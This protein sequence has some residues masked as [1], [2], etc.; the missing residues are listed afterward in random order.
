MSGCS[1]LLCDNMIIEDDNLGIVMI[2]LFK[3]VRNMIK[4]IKKTIQ[5]LN[6]VT[7]KL[8]INLDEGVEEIKIYYD[9]V[10]LLSLKD[11]IVNVIKFCMSNYTFRSSIGLATTIF[12]HYG[13]TKSLLPDKFYFN[14]HYGET[15]VIIN[16]TKLTFKG[17]DFINSDSKGWLSK[18][19]LF[20]GLKRRSA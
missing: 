11:I 3:Y 17:C 1:E 10:N 2:K 19:V 7:V 13:F 6:V 20:D 14:S 12:P 15:I 18:L 4:I 16:G 8:L 5:S 9:I